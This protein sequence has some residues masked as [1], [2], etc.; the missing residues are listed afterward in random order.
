MRRI[1]R[2]RIDPLRVK[3]TADAVG[4][5]LRIGTIAD[6]LK[7]APAANPE[8]AAWRRDMVGT[9]LDSAIR[10]KMIAGGS[11]AGVSTIRRDTLAPSGNPDDQIGTAHRQAA[12]ASGR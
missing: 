4:D 8:M 11:P 2:R 3:R 9:G 5:I 6:M 10:A 12:M 1:N 7:L